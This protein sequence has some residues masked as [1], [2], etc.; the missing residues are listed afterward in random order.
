[1][2][3]DLASAAATTKGAERLYRCAFKH[4]DGR[5]CFRTT[6]HVGHKHLL[7]KT[8]YPTPELLS[9]LLSTDDVSSPL[10]GAVDKMRPLAARWDDVDVRDAFYKMTYS[11]ER[12]DYA[13]LTKTVETVLREDRMLAR[14]GATV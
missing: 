10:P 4:T 14:L 9:G 1:M 11:I 13:L 8:G 2:A 5:Q 3:D 6:D 12:K 7:A